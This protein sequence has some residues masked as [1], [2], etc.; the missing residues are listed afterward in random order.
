M[1]LVAHVLQEGASADAGLLVL[2]V[3]VGLL[4][5]G[6]AVQ[7]SLGRLGGDGLAATAAIFDRVGYRP[8]RPMVVIAAASET[9]GA[10]LLIAG[11]VTPLAGAIVA[12][13]M[14]VA[15]SVH[16]PYGVWAA[17]RGF[18]L[19]LTFGIAGATLA[20]VGPGR[21]SLDAAFGIDLPAWSGAAAL[22]VCLAG[23]AA[24]IAVRA[25]NQRR[26]S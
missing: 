21:W 1:A 11:L 15:C 25:V 16:W 2:R 3:A 17:Q 24:L 7:K 19:P 22:A 4:V 5:L 6:H 14:V 9:V 20:L 13:V 12:A 23:A 18:E 8:G 26:P 10:V